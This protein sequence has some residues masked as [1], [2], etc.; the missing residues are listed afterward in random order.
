[1]RFHLIVISVGLL[2]LSNA[3]AG[4]G[5]VK[6]GVVGIPGVLEVNKSGDYDKVLARVAAVA[7]KPFNYVVLPPNRIEAELKSGDIDCLLPMDARYWKEK[8]NYVNS[9]P[10][11]AA[12]PNSNSRLPPSWLAAWQ[13]ASLSCWVS[14]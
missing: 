5:E 2:A 6:L 11:N 8:G 13:A 10:L 4:A 3:I 12:I 7:G 1:M 14:A 9:E